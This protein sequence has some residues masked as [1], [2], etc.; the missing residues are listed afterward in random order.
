MAVRGTRRR[1]NESYMASSRKALAA[2]A[3]RAAAQ[4]ASRPALP[5]AIQRN[6]ARSAT[7]WQEAVNVTALDG[8]QIAT[9][10]DRS[11]MPF[12]PE[13]RRRRRAT[14]VF[15]H[16]RRRRDQRTP[17]K[18]SAVVALRAV[19]PTMS[20]IS[21][22]VQAISPPMVPNDSWRFAQSVGGGGGSGGS[23]HFRLSRERQPD[24][25]RPRRN[26]GGG[27]GIGKSALAGQSPSRSR[28]PP[29]T[30]HRVRTGIPA[31]SIG[32]AGGE[33]L[34][35]QRQ[36]R[37]R[38]SGAGTA[39]ESGLAAAAA[40]ATAAAPYP[41]PTAK[42]HPGRDG[43][44]ALAA[45][46]QRHERRRWRGSAFRATRRRGNQSECG[47]RRRRRRRQPRQHRSISAPRARPT[48]GILLT[49]GDQTP[50]GILAQSIGGKG[51][52][53]RQRPSPARLLGPA[54]PWF[55]ASA[56]TAAVGG[57]GGEVNVYSG[58]SIFTEGEQSH[59]IFARRASRRGRR[60]PGPERHRRC[61]GLW[62]P[63]TE[64]G[65]RWRRSGKYGGIGQCSHQ[66]QSIDAQGEYAHGIR[67][68]EYWRWRQFRRRERLG[69][70]WP[71]QLSLIPIPDEYPTRQHQDRRS[72][73]AAPA[74]RG[75]KAA[76]LQSAAT[77]NGSG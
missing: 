51:G 34:R 56:A 57:Y 17:V 35:H 53:C 52:G 15:R 2:A 11:R 28:K 4:P 5:A 64:H 6:R 19:T 46:R 48:G 73:W 47:N 45:K 24:S 37:Q 41:V 3:V 67:G 77:N 33:G 21:Q 40:A 75:G 66:R 76:K 30:W 69:E 58:S 49:K 18:A 36:H 29:S 23:R 8:S 27:S 1:L 14:A 60:Q 72:P 74:A 13:C 54:W 32:R 31:Q 10:G 62:R 22:L 61:L 9:D 16:L 59:G 42:R 71:T 50:S 38:R 39:T 44:P 25:R 12:C 26:L 70:P 63:V 43:W 55:S 7:R 68:A 20:R 65:R